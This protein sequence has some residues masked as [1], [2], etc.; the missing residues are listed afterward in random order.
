MCNGKS[1]YWH[2]WFLFGSGLSCLILV[3]GSCFLSCRLRISPLMILVTFCISI[4]SFVVSRWIGHHRDSANRRTCTPRGSH[5]PKRDV[6]PRRWARHSGDRRSRG[7]RRA[8]L[9]W[10]PQ[11]CLA[12][13][14]CSG[15]AVCSR[16]PPCPCRSCT[17]W[18]RG[19]HS[20]TLSPNFH[21]R[22]TLP[23]IWS[24]RTF[25][26]RKQIF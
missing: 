21:R 24:F 14:K 18:S 4:L 17:V 9:P 13:R 3:A 25:L 22:R 15:W 11:K 8:F 19:S 16:T 10:R 7:R 5:C 2:R 20:W 23:Q 1:A 26:S 12:A 6:D